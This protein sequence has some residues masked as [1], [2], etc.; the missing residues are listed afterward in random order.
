M[1]ALFFT[2][3]SVYKLPAYNDVVAALKGDRPESVH[4]LL[5]LLSGLPYTATEIHS[6]FVLGQNG[7]RN[8]GSVL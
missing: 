4:C 1:F 2:H 8:V 3:R 5:M 6:A 7:S